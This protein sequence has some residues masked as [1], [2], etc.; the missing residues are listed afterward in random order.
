[1]VLF[2]QR[3][4]KTDGPVFAPPSLQ[5]NG[6]VDSP[7]STALSDRFLEGLLQVAERMRQTTSHF[8]EPVI[9]GSDFNRHGSISPGRL[10]TTK[11]GH[12]SDHGASFPFQW[13]SEEMTHWAQRG[14]RARQTYRPCKR[15][16]CDAEVH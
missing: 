9:D 14:V 7:A 12:A 5:R 16:R 8:E 1:M 2:R 10:S 6:E 3:L 11:S 15:S 4:V 13:Q